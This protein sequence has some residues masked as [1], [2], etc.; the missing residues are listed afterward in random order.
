MTFAVGHS[1]F[2]IHTW[3]SRDKR[4][5]NV[6]LTVKGDQGKSHFDRL[7]KSK[8]QTEGLISPELEWQENPKENY[9]RLYLEDTDLDDRDDW[10]R[11]HQWLCEQLE[12]FYVVFSK[13]VKALP[14]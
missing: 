7:K 11:Q 13:W 14:K 8:T 3:A 6:G 5:I 9:I 4:Y 12:I 10:E 1:G 2:H